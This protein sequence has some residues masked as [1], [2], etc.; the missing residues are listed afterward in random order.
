M[1]GPKRISHFLL[2]ITLVSIYSL[3]EMFSHSHE[4][5]MNHE[6]SKQVTEVRRLV[7][8]GL[9]PNE[10]EAIKEVAQGNSTLIYTLTQ[11]MKD[12]GFRKGPH[13]PVTKEPKVGLKKHNSKEQLAT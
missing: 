7:N 6:L 4:S 12:R 10:E 5:L 9:Q 11:E 13:A 3:T 8:T 2:T 1:A